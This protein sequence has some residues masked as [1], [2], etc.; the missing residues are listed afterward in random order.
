M[1]KLYQYES[2][3]NQ[4][5][6]TYEYFLKQ[7]W[8]NDKPIYHVYSALTTKRFKIY[9]YLNAL[10]RIFMKICHFFVQNTYFENR[11]LHKFLTEFD[12]NYCN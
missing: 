4:Y 8:K 3:N 10:A 6:R 1:S 2:S 12:K 7:I 5:K 11:F 9:F